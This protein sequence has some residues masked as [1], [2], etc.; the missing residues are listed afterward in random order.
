M[1]QKMRQAIQT[2]LA[3][4]SARG[5]LIVAERSAHYVHIDEPEIVIEAIR[6]TGL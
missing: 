3:Q 1:F 6:E 4:R 5:T 2:E